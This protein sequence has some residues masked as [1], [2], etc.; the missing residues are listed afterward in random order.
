MAETARPVPTVNQ[1][2]DQLLH[3]L[4]DNLNTVPIT[5]LPIG[6]ANELLN[7]KKLEIWEAFD[8]FLT[9]VLTELK[10]QLL[11]NTKDLDMA[12]LIKVLNQVRNKG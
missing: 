3:R 7:I 1:V 10:D 12:T 8:V 4:S 9:E 2:R 6:V 5:D 11:T